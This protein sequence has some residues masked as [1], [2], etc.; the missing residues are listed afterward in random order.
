MYRWLTHT[1]ARIQKTHTFTASPT[2]T[3]LPHIQWIK[4]S[5]TRLPEHAGALNYFLFQVLNW[6][7]S[8]LTMAVIF[9]WIKVWFK[10]TPAFS[11]LVTPEI[12]TLQLCRF[13]EATSLCFCDSQCAG[14]SAVCNFVSCIQ[15]ISF[16]YQRSF[17]KDVNGT[18]NCTFGSYYNKT[19]LIGCI[20]LWR[21]TQ[22]GTLKE[23]KALVFMIQMHVSKGKVTFGVFR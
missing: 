16:V 22:L 15:S 9:C 11:C 21:A 2:A 4:K 6:I 12:E 17:Q 8:M 14:V 18:C 19:A 23:K 20:L 3:H 10:M 13:C 5:A 1:H 7:R